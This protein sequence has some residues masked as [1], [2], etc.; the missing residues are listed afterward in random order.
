M[1]PGGGSGTG[2]R[3]VSATT[4]WSLVAGT[5]HGMTC[6]PVVSPFTTWPVARHCGLWATAVLLLGM[7]SVNT[8]AIAAHHNVIFRKFDMLDNPFQAFL[9]VQPSDLGFQRVATVGDCH[10][11]TK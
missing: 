4:T 3:L 6:S 9:Q 11:G 1:L 2:S 10:G 8:P 7:I 5:G